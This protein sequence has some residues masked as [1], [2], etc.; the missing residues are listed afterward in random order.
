MDGNIPF[1]EQIGIL[2]RWSDLSSLAVTFAI[3]RRE[4]F[5]RTMADALL[6]FRR[7]RPNATAHLHVQS[8]DVWL[9][10]I[11]PV[12]RPRA[13]VKFLGGELTFTHAQTSVM[14]EPGVK[15]DLKAFANG[16]PAARTLMV[17]PDRWHGDAVFAGCMAAKGKG[18]EFHGFTNKVA[19]ALG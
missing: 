4:D 8:G 9:Q 15:G 5:A 7:H 12:E 13:A 17:G 6:E 16:H 11:M 14:N 18:D 10:P 2:C 3:G 1:G 19:G